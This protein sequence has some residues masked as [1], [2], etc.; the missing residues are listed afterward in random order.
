M[1]AMLGAGIAFHT[2]FLVFGSR[3]LIDLADAGADKAT[4]PA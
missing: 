2:A 3:A 4:A 1:G